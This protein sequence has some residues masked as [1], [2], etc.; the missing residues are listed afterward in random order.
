[1]VIRLVLM[2]LI[3]YFLLE[4]Y[5]IFNCTDFESNSNLN[6]LS[7]CEAILCSIICCYK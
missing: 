5:D 3:N 2:T 1:M 6:S 7:N 4:N